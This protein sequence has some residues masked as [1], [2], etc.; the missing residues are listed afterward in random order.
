ML[1]KGVHKVGVPRDHFRVAFEH[2]VHVRVRHAFGGT[3][4]AGREIGGN[5]IAGLV[6]FH[7]DAHHQPIDVRIQRANPV[8]QFL[9]EHGDCPIRKIDGGAAHARFAVEG[10]PGTHVMRHVRDVHLKF[11][12]AVR[13]TRHMNRVIEIACGFSVNRDDRK[14]AKIAAAVQI[15]LRC[16]LRR[17][18]RLRQHFC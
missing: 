15:V 10:R 7:Q 13:T 18:A 9:G 12:A 1:L 14:I 6:H 3:N 8:G 2:L 16:F 11:V 4:H 17:G 5:Q